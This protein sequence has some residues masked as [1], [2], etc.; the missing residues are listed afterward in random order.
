[1]QTSYFTK[2]DFKD[3]PQAKETKMT[4]N[5]EIK[6]ENTKLGKIGTVTI[7]ASAVC[8]IV[9]HPTNNCQLF[10]IASFGNIISYPYLKAVLE[11]ALMW[12]DNKPLL[13][14]DIHTV[15]ADRFS[16]LIDKNHIVIQQNYVSSNKSLMTIMLLKT[17]FIKE[18]K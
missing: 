9:H 15:H 12:S 17:A 6:T 5:I 7:N 4:Y 14:I 16:K 13:L 18:L 1:M 8:Y 3:W 10:T 11:K 2:E